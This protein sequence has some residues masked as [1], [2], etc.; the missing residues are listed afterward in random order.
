[1]I[2]NQIIRLAGMSNNQSHWFSN[3]EIN[4]AILKI[5]AKQINKL[6][7]ETLIFS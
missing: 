6:R 3:R 4:Q 2:L 7:W 1:M 5:R